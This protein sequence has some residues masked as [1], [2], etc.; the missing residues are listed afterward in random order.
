MIRANNIAFGGAHTF[1]QPAAAVLLAIGLLCVLLLP[2]KYASVAFVAAACFISTTEHLVIA[3]QVFTPLRLLILSALPRVISSI[4]DGGLRPRLG[5]PLD[6]AW[7]LVYVSGALVFSLQWF[8]I[9]AL[10]Q[11]LGI[12]LD[13]VGG[14]IV[15]RYMIR[16]KADV[17]RVLRVFGIL[18]C[19]FA[20]SMLYERLT[21]RNLLSFVGG[22]DPWIREYS[23]RAQ[24]TFV[25]AILAGVFGA[26]L[27]PV[28][29]GYLR[30]QAGNARLAMIFSA[31]ALVMVLT[32]SSSTPTLACAA[33]IIA[34]LCW[35]L[36]YRT[37]ELKYAFCA[38]I[39]G[40]HLVMKA[41]VWALIQRADSVGGGTG[42][43]R[44]VIVDETIRHFWRW[45]LL[46]ATDYGLWGHDMWD[47]A[48]TYVSA[49]LT[50]GLITLIL[51]IVLLRRV[52][53]TL[54]RFRNRAADDINMQR[55][56]WSLTA[57]ALTHAVAFFG[58][59]YM[60]QT[61]VLWMAFLVMV[62]VITAD[63]GTTVTQPILRSNWQRITP[64]RLPASAGFTR[65][66][67]SSQR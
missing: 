30:R 18:C 58:I 33:G 67:P 24:A 63:S 43:H 50:G 31:A 27:L 22:V 44:F 36:R 42:Y 19:V 62:G 13:A 66:S 7:I 4:V 12:L 37:R 40:L 32:S 64:Q 5:T 34:L 54:S 55:C 59:T 29:W 28:F 6:K 16:D 53:L 8:S 56:S 51:L 20:L 10:V 14:Y 41:P 49:A 21:M 35:P 1:L 25:H 26:T 61:I 2:R 65:F 11:R 57:A 45:A 9:P 60:D 38:A 15:L 3:G 48:N 46:G 52:F 23:A 39:V 17:Q 47:L